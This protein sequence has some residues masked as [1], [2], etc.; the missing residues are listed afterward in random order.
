[1]K[2]NSYF[3]FAILYNLQ[4]K[5]EGH[6][7]QKNVFLYGKIIRNFCAWNAQCMHSTNTLTETLTK[8]LVS[9][10]HETEQVKSVEGNGVQMCCY[11][12]M[13]NETSFLQILFMQMQWEEWQCW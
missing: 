1:M 3:I 9:K 5:I 12:Y 2:L 8:I 13:C 4:C 11:L 6:V 7:V 10:V